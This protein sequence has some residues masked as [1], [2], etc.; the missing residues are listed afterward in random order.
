MSVTL[1]HSPADI[2]RE[3]LVSLGVITDPDVSPGAAWP[4]FVA[5][6]PSSPDNV[7]TLFDTTPQADGRSMIDGEV[8][9]HYGIQIRVRSTTHP[10]GYQKAE[11]LR[12]A[13]AESLY[14]RPVNLQSATYLV[15][16][17]TGLSILT[18]GKEV[19]LAKRFLFTINC[20]VVL[21]TL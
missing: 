14:N 12:R 6:E 7:I 16:C 4:A 10:I 2:L 9:Y 21:D 20:F 17:V 15:R 13:M 1:E 3:A 18:L 8:D 5:G 19:P 11:A